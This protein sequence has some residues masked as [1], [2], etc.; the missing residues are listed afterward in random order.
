PSPLPAKRSAVGKP[1]PLPAKRSA[2]GRGWGGAASEA[3]GTLSCRRL[4][5]CFVCR[6][7]TTTFSLTPSSAGGRRL[8]S[9]LPLR[10]P[11]ADDYTRQTQ[12]QQRGRT[13]LGHGFHR[14]SRAGLIAA[15]GQSGH[16]V[17]GVGAPVAVEVA[18]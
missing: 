6:R 11:E 14:G 18:A 1:S 9:H 17:A 4:T 16:Q 13:W 15:V 3:S 5:C 12:Y 10:L 2:V 7:Q 8:R